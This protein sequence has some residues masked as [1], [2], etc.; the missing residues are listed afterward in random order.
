MNLNSD[1]VMVSEFAPTNTA[2]RVSRSP[3]RISVLA[4]AAVLLGGAGVSASAAAGT[5]A[6]VADFDPGQGQFPESITIDARGSVYFSGFGGSIWRVVPDGNHQPTLFATVPV[7]PPP[8]NC[9]PLGVKFGPDGYLY[10]T[11]ACF[12]TNPS[13]SQVW[14]ISPTGEVEEYARLDPN[15]APNDLAFDNAGNLFVTDGQLGVVWKIGPGGEARNVV[16]TVWLASPLLAPNPSD[17]GAPNGISVGANGIAF[18]AGK[19]NLYV[20][21][22]DNGQVLKIAVGCDGSAGAVTTFASDARLKGLDGIA[23]D[24]RGTLYG[25]GNPA[26]QIVTI[27]R[28]GFVNVVASGS[29]F[30]TPASLVFGSPNVWHGNTLYVANFAIQELL[31]GLEPHPSLLRMVVPVPGLPLP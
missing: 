28:K 26:S 20:G 31:D 7:P 15:G 19:R 3:L 8:A 30:D 5:V 16:P 25:A 24:A 14:R 2:C 27:D 17:P 9:R 6:V 4:V 1:T 29:A 12:M 10:T 11:S 13:V 21:N 22:F 23:F 18:D